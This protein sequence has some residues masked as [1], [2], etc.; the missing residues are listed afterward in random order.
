MIFN[1][2]IIICE[3]GTEVVDRELTTPEEA[4]TP[5]Q[6]M[7]YIEWEKRLV[8]MDRM[9]QKETRRQTYNLKMKINPF[10]KMACICKL[11]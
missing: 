10:Y 1:F 3:D 8:F 2:R 4:L 9:R 7:D 5:S 11:I 6:Q